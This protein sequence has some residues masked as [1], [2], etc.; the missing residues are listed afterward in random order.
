MKSKDEMHCRVIATQ[1]IARTNQNPEYEWRR[2]APPL[3]FIDLLAQ[4][5][6]REA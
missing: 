6:V 3:I 2:F 4:E 1:E 5:E